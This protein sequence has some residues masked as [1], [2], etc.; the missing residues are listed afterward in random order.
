MQLPEAC[1]FDLDGV[2]LDTEDLHS[3]AWSEAAKSFGT[4]LRDDQLILLKGRRRHDCAKQIL[5]WL[6]K[7]ITIKDFLAKHQPISQKLMSK[8]QAMQGAKELIRWCFEKNLPMALVTSSSTKSIELKSSSHSWL[9][10]ITTRVQGDDPN[11]EEGK[12]APDPFV[13]AAKKLKVNPKNCWA[14]EDSFSGTQSALKAGCH[15]WVLRCPGKKDFEFK[16]LSM[17]KLYYVNQLNEV[18]NELKEI[19]L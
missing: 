5:E 19:L 16:S 7:R 12:P 1:L 8:V 10:L 17:Q 9:E 3:E 18:L 15:V 14:I 13:L 2:L 11:L 6:P 4:E